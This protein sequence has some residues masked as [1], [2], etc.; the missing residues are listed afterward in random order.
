[1]LLQTH[2]GHMIRSSVVH[3]GT[4]NFKLPFST[5]KIHPEKT[6]ND[7]W[8]DVAN[9]PE[10]AWFFIFFFFALMTDLYIKFNLKNK[11][12][13]N[14]Q[15]NKN[16]WTNKSLKKEMDMKWCH[17]EVEQM[18]FWRTSS[19]GGFWW[20]CRSNNWAL[21]GPCSRAQQQQHDSN[22]TSKIQI[23]RQLQERDHVRSAADWWFRLLS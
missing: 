22:G 17:H 16:S 11:I 18:Y 12:M 8:T 6:T 19:G 15:V 5:L 10:Y 4:S 23:I 20:L 9:K 14:K 21:K 3:H 7:I 2:E 13:V 1:M